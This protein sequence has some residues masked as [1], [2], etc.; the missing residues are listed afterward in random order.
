MATR[1]MEKVA[2]VAKSAEQESALALRKSQENHRQISTQLEQLKA[3]KQEYEVNFGRMGDQGIGARQLQ[4]YRLF[5]SKLGD[6]INQQSESVQLAVKAL[7]GAREQWQ[8]KSLHRSSLDKLLDQR[9]KDSVLA[10]DKA[11]Q[12]ESDERALTRDN[13]AKTS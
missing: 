8:L 11:E 4:D 10:A 6:A 5:L 3:F 9:L 13:N 1:K 12:R 2:I 7:H